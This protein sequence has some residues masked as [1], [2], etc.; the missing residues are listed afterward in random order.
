[1][2]APLLT[3]EAAQ[4]PAA[5]VWVEQP[6]TTRRAYLRGERIKGGG[7]NSSTLGAFEQE[8]AARRAQLW[9]ATQMSTPTLCGR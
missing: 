7:E 6:A 9:C 4:R 8:M 3:K 5:A 2:S 1:M